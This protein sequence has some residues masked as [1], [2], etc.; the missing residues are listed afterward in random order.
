MRYNFD[1]IINRK[2]TNSIKWDFG[3]LLKEFGI[4]DRFD[5]DTLPL[6]TA[7]MDIACPPEIV[8]AMHRTA[9]QRIYGYS[10]LPNEYYQSIINWFDK[11]H[12]WSI[13]KEEIV[14]CPGTVHAIG[15]AIEA[16]TKK[17]D[18]VI[19]QRPVYTPFTAKIEGASRVVAN[20]QM[21]LND[22]HTYSIDLEDFE[23]LA[24]KKENTMFILC[25]PHNPTGRIFSN[26]ELKRMA[27]IC[28][29]NDVVIVADEIHGDLIRQ[30]SVFTPIVKTTDKTNH[31]VTCTAINKT[32]NVA[33]LHASNIV[34]S[35]KLLRA[36][37]KKVLGMTLP[38]PFTINAV[39]SAYTQCEEW[40]DQI[41]TYF[42]NSLEWV[43]D[44]LRKNMPTV[45][46]SRPEG[47]YI[48]WMDFRGYN[49]SKEEIK[50]RI[51]VDA[52]V[53]LESGP[54]FDPDKGAGF[55]RICLS[56]PLPIVKEAFNRIAKAFSD[57][58]V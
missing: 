54:M 31:I 40:L 57:L 37:F 51:Y 5:K 14:Y 34:I 30:D 3:E 48:F 16:Y 29:E 50:K 53:V 55:E 33:G 22:D 20:N 11:R 56:S 43:T 45:R 49:I 17:G 9:D 38:T 25:N 8:E 7:D 21:I 47:T 15:I 32:F 28:H 42:D 1:E 35:D 36:K 10:A 23:E 41:I 6:F 24:K 2:N 44:F 4:T 46:F 39:I 13:K 52:N 18:G 19:I 12:N 26:H 27:E 58:E